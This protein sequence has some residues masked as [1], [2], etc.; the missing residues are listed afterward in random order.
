[1][2]RPRLRFAG[3]A[4]LALVPFLAAAS[5]PPAWTAQGRV[6]LLGF[7]GASARTIEEL[8]DADP[9]RYP[10]FRRLAA[11]GTFAPLEVVVPPES[12]VSW[13][14]INTGQNP[15]KTGVPG[16]IRRSLEGGVPMP[17]FGHLRT[18]T[19]PAADFDHQ[20]LPA[21][22]P[23]VW[24]G[25][26][27]GAAFVL[28]ALVALLATRGRWPIA[29]VLALVAGGAAG[30]S[31]RRLPAYLPLDVPHTGNPLEARNFWDFAG[32]AGVR[33]VILV[34]AQAFD[35]ETPPGVDLLA[36]LGVPD[37]RGAIGDWFL[38][39]TDPTEVDRV[40]RGRRTTTA[41]TVYRVD[42]YD[43]VIQSRVYG[44]ENFWRRQR[45]ERE[46]A[47]L[48]GRL[49]D[50][51]L[52]YEASI[53]LA[54][55]RSEV[56]EELAE[57]KREPTGVDLV[58]TREG[59]AAL[60]RI[61]DQEE[62][63]RE[64]E[65]SDFFELEF[66]LNRF[67]SVRAITRARLVHL[68][69]PHFELFLNVLEIDPRS[70]PFWQPISS[71]FGYSAELADAC[72]L[73]ET[74]GWSTATMPFKDG[75]VSPELL[76]ED[77]EFTMRWRERLLHDQLARDDWRCLM[78]VFSTTDR[79]Q[80]MMYQFYDPENPMHD[81]AVAAREMEF[82]GERIRLGDAIPAIYR[83]M[84]RI[85]GDVLAR[86]APEDTLLVC[87]DH[88]FQSF[89]RQVNVNNWLA[90]QGYLTLVPGAQKGSAQMLQYVDWDRT[91]AYSLGMGF[92]YLN[93]RGREPRGVVAPEEADALLAEIRERFL[94]AT[95][96]ET[97]ERF[98]KAV[99]VVADEHSGPYLDR[100]GDLILGFAPR[101]R[102][103]WSATSGG[104]HMVKDELGIWQPGPVCVDNDS[105]WSGDHTSAALEDVQGVFLSNRR[106]AGEGPVHALQIAPTVLDLVGVPVPAVMDREPMRLVK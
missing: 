52:E 71:P 72:G 40:P 28:V 62:R 7:D 24:T 69:E 101:Y 22:S 93:L 79:V 82:F 76:M 88:G 97:G 19:R 80:H 85:L 27:G 16:F 100:E 14:A 66:E 102:V 8:A 57:V 92:V 95:D 47:E 2:N 96:P 61:G 98:C 4:P 29:L 94:A 6:V 10:T 99:Y 105:P 83:Q 46:L 15:A 30:W 12:P 55:R 51:A 59:D 39:T 37:A 5:I 60:V 89:H 70:P 74:Y 91:R 58:V 36:G 65:W 44:P 50:P 54:S 68:A 49:N 63:L 53:E 103:S 3:L 25:V 42:E 43:G 87:S 20:P 23:G 104:L 56:R 11:S 33:C 73:F 13:A 64:G 18:G 9:E 31:A 41:G 67:L 86:L 26:A 78:A 34:P 75:A 81:P 77:V 45:L 84:D 38:Y 21:W 17:D 90:E 48:E 35:R 1:M 32:D 106:L